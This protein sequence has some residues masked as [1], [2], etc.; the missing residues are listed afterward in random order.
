[1]Y[2]KTIADKFNE[3]YIEG[4]LIYT[5]NNKPNIEIWEDLAGNNEIFYMEFAR[6]ITNE[7][8]PEADDIFDPEEFDNYVN[9]KLALDRHDNGPEFAR[10]NMRLKDKDDRLIGIAVDNLVLDT[11]MYKVEYADGYKTSMTAN[12]IASNFFSE[13]TKMNNVLYYSMKS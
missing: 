6:V 5:P 1:M 10:V 12:A 11:S 7:D 3:F 13:S 8:I 9:I 2:D 4:N